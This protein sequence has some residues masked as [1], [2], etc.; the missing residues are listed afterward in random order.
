[1]LRIIYSE[2]FVSQFESLEP[3]IQKL[4]EKN[5]EMFIIDHR[6]PSLKT[7][8]LNG[9]LEDYFSFSVDLQMR[10]VF[11]YGAKGI[12]HFLKIGNHDVYR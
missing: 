12:V 11:E 2:K 10:I 8:K 9:M 5:I 1:M 3:R 6:H 7:H 4:A